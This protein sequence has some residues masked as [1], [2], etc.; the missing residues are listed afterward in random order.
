[1]NEPNPIDFMA[2]EGWGQDHLTRFQ[3]DAIQN[4]FAAFVHDPLWRK[5]LSDIAADLSKCCEYASANILNSDDPSALLLFMSANSHFLASARLVASG[6]CLSTHPTIRS[7]VESALYGW[8]LAVTPGAAQRW[9]NKPTDRLERKEWGKEF[10][11]SALNSVLS[12]TFK[13]AAEWAKH[14]H[15]STIDFGAHP[16]RDALYSNFARIPRA[17]GSSILRFTVLHP[18]G[19]FAVLTTKL[20]VETGMLVVGLFGRAFPDADKTHGLLK[21]TVNYAKEL[22]TLVAKTTSFDNAKDK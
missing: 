5:L 18:G 12:G 21:A 6:L 17:D 2:P 7:A 16:N 1:M 19:T 20:L 11:F 13:G 4:E 14:L 15:Q 3:S 9:Y 8:Y 10:Q 22:E